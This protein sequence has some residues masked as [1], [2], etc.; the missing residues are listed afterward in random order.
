MHVLH[1]AK[2]NRQT[3]KFPHCK[4]CPSKMMIFFHT[5]LHPYNGYWGMTLLPVQNASYFVNYVNPSVIDIHVRQTV[6]SLS[7]FYIFGY[8]MVSNYF[9]VILQYLI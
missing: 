9:L 7:A 1:P 8:E 6:D 2:N 4:N 3:T 5:Y